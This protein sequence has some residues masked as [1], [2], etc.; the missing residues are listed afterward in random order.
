MV[1]TTCR[2]GA[3]KAVTASPPPTRSSRLCYELDYEEGGVVLSY[4]LVCGMAEEAS[5]SAP[6]IMS[7]GRMLMPILA[8]Y[9][10]MGVAG[11][12]LLIAVIVVLALVGRKMY[13][14]KRGKQTSMW[15]PDG[16]TVLVKDDQI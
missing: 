10:A 3:F 13:R 8:P 1:N 4:K 2:E 7:I 12:A 11:G 5:I 6:F 14:A 16:E 9:I 15:M